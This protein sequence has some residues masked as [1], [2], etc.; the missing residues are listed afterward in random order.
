MGEHRPR[1]WF[2]EDALRVLARNER[3]P[4]ALPQRLHGMAAAVCS[5]PAQAD[6]QLAP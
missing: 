3:P 6:E 2:L 1:G 4:G 5:P